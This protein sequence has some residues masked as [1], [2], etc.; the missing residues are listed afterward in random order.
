[1]DCNICNNAR[2]IKDPVLWRF[3]ACKC[4]EEIIKN[5]S[6]KHESFEERER[7]LNDENWRMLHDWK[8]G[9]P[10]DDKDLRR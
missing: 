8:N 3:T 9:Y 7:R 2:I 1:M 5:R 6:V 10:S 4:C